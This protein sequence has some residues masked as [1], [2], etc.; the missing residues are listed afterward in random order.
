[1]IAKRRFRIVVVGRG[2][3]I[4]GEL[5]SVSEKEVTYEGGETSTSLPRH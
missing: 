1:M 3:G 4:G 5:T 2:H